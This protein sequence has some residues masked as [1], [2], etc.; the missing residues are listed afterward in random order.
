[1]PPPRAGPEVEDIV[2]VHVRKQG[3]D[4]S[5]LRSA[6]LTRSPFPILQHAYVQPFLD[7]THDAP[8]RYPVL[9]EL[10]EPFVGDGIEVPTNVRIE[11]PVHLPPLDPDVER[12]QCIVRSALGPEPVGEADEVLLIDAVQDRDEGTLDQLVLQ[13]GDP[14]WSLP[15]VRLGDEHP[16]DGLRPVRS[17]SQPFGEI[18]QMCLEMLSVRPP[19][20]PVYPSCRVPLEAEV[21]LAQ[22]LDVVD[23]VQERRE[24]S[25][26][27]CPRCLP[28]AVP[29]TRHALPAQCPERVLRPRIPHGLPP[30]LHPL[31]GRTSLST[32]TFRLRLAVSGVSTFVPV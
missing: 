32:R 8:V 7:E 30:S 25:P 28:Y 31:R 23:V 17:S 26:L 27:V 4:A 9:D 12:V 2:Q 18:D 6:H 5:S 3:R 11:H 19:S 13:R 20:L 15:S 21:S 14:E 1:M 22:A 16:P 29:R 10:H 24:P